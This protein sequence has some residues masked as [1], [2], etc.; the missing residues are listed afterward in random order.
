MARVLGL[1]ARVRGSGLGLGARAG[2][3]GLE[4]VGRGAGAGGQRRT[5]GPCDAGPPR[6]RARRPI[7][8]DGRGAF[9]DRVCRSRADEGAAPREPWVLPLLPVS[10]AVHRLTLPEVTPSRPRLWRGEH[11]A[12]LAGLTV[13]RWRVRRGVRARGGVWGADRRGSGVGARGGVWGVTGVGEACERGAVC[14]ERGAG[15]RRCSLRGARGRRAR[16]QREDPGLARRRPLVRWIGRDRVGES[17]LVFGTD[18][19]AS[20]CPG[21][22]RV[23]GPHRPSAPSPAREV[24]PRG[25]RTS[26]RGRAPRELRESSARAPRGRACEGYSLARITSSGMSLLTGP[27][28]TSQS[29]WAA[30]VA[31]MWRRWRD[32]TTSG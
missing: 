20:T 16:E 8:R 9:T 32:S 19:A 24:S 6:T 18:G 12:A 7:C 5:A 3:A 29:W 23:A 28:Q 14:G 15:R 10:T 27:A 17:D 26:P 21:R 2:D 25:G 31:A 1:G 4:C 30:R 13:A 22:T 11:G